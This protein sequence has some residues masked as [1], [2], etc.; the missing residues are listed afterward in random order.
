MQRQSELNSAIAHLRHH[1][2]TV[3]LWNASPA[4]FR[5]YRTAADAMIIGK[6]ALLDLARD[7]GWKGLAA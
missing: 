1:D 3:R 6:D 5:V 4:E 7:K 2:L